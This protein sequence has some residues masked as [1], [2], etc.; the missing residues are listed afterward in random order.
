MANCHPRYIGYLQVAGHSLHEASYLVPNIITLISVPS[1]CQLSRNG[2]ARHCT[3]LLRVGRLGC[4]QHTCNL[5]VASVAS[6]VPFMYHFVACVCVYASF[7]QPM[8]QAAPQMRYEPGKPC[9][10]HSCL[11]SSAAYVLQHQPGSRPSCQPSGAPS[12]QDGGKRELQWRW[13]ST[14]CCV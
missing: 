13:F 10:A 12:E 9:P 7:Q 2:H 3:C 11:C 8:L 5:C 6:D 4:Y 14:S 1:C